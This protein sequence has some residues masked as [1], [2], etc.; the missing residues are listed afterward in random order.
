MDPEQLKQFLEGQKQQME[1][2]QQMFVQLKTSK[3]IPYPV[4]APFEQIQARDRKIF[5]SY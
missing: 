2:F 1:L 5:S 3:I 4:A